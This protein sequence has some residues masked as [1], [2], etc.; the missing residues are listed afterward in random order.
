MINVWRHGAFG[1]GSKFKWGVCMKKILGSGR[2]GGQGM[3]QGT[4]WKR[5]RE[6]ARERDSA[7][8]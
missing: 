7:K 3:I 5:R 8:L 2:F 6:S 1:R 4:R